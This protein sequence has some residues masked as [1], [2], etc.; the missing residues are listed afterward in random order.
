[1][2]HAMFKSSTIRTAQRKSGC[3][4]VDPTIFKDD[5]FT[6][7][8]ST[9][10]SA[11]HVPTSFPTPPPLKHEFYDDEQ[12]LGL[13]NNGEHDSSD[14]DSESDSGSESDDDDISQPCC[15]NNLS[16][17][18]TSVSAPAA[19]DHEMMQPSSALTLP[20]VSQ[21]IPP[22]TF[23]VL[24]TRSCASQGTSLKHQLDQLEDNN[25]A[26]RSCISTLE[27]HCVMAQ[28]EIQDLKCRTNAWD[29]HS[30]KRPKLNVDARCLTSEEGLRLS[31]EQKAL[32]AA[33][34]QKKRE[35]QEQQAAK[36]AEQQWQ[37]MEQDADEPFFSA[38]TTKLKPDLQDVAQALGISIEGSKKILLE[39]INNH[40]E[41][42]PDLRSSP[43][44]EG[45]F[46]R[47]RR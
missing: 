19:L 46:N 7:S 33:Q 44:Y 24:I 40:F 1:V 9:S 31:Q 37:W 47:S 12:D 36:E 28:S 13:G 4:P 17:D 23:Y 27:A 26:L 45:L 34:D 38:L 42:N 39:H 41:A 2:W 20:S 15:S 6:P 14:S 11:S 8:I 32:K 35:A 43:Q 5:D 16:P 22:R 10:T 30:R 29:S 3:W 18:A 21:T 25:T